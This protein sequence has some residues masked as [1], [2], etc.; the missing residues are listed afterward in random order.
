MVN[1]IKKMT[2]NNSKLYLGYLNKLVGECNN[3]Y[4]QSVS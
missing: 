1:S 4:C 3:A 2:A